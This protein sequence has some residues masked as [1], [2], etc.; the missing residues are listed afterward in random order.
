MG[1]PHKRPKPNPSKGQ[2][3]DPSKAATKHQPEARSATVKPTA[4]TTSTVSPPIATDR[5]E[6]ASNSSIKSGVSGVMKAAEGGTPEQKLKQKASWYGTW[7]RKSTASTQIARETILADKPTNGSTSADLNRF[8]PKKPPVPKTERPPSMYLGKSKETSEVTMSSTLEGESPLNTDNKTSNSMTKD[9]KGVEENGSSAPA[10]E[11]TAEPKKLIEGPS[12]Q[13]ELPPGSET[14]ERPATASGWLGGW[15]STPK[16]QPQNLAE[17]G[18]QTPET[19]ELSKQAE[20]QGVVEPQPQPQEPLPATATEEKPASI[21]AGSTSWFGLWSTAAPS[22]ATEEPEPKVLVK[23]TEADVD[24][25]M[26]DAPAPKQN[27]EPVAESSSWAFWST[28]TSKKAGPAG[29][30]LQDVG[31]VA[32]SGEPSQK[33]PE[34]AKA[35]TPKE[36]KIDKSGKRR[37]PQSTETIESLRP[38]T[39]AASASS[40]AVQTPPTVAKKVPPNLLIPSVK[41]TYRLVE[42]PSILQQ[43]ARLLLHAQQPPAKHVFL[44][45]EPPM[46]KKALAIGIH[47]LF[48]APLLR[49]VMGQ[50]TGTSV[51]F[52]N[53]AADAIRRWTDAHGSLDCEIEK[54]ALEGEGKIADRADNL[55]KLLLNWIDHVRKADFILVACH[56]QGVPVALML[57]A[58]LI[59]FGVVTTG[60]IGVC[61]MAGVSLGPFADYKSRLFSGSAGELFEFA[62]PESTVSKRY[63][64]SLRVAVK[65]GVRVTYCGSIDDQLISMES[66]IF[67]TASHPY[68]Y[69]AVFVD[70]RIHAPDFLSHLVGFALKLRNLGVSDHGLI[71]EL[72]APLAGSLYTG[73][74]H[75]RLYDDGNI[76]DVAVEFAL[77]TTSVGDI[78]LELKKYEIP[79]TSNPYVLPWIMRGLLEED[80]VKTEL[81]AETTELL[82]EFDDWK[83]ATKVL[84]DVKYRLE[85]VRSKL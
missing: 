20:L 44:V 82:K 73:E 80:F 75:S 55:W 66:S 70:G 10:D 22:T 47:G 25:V 14:A 11:P 3:Q 32:V 68:I 69:R 48:P 5:S 54:V 78:P 33:N 67:S 74:G 79:N 34:P 62:D 57:V 64:D 40:A 50:P 83:P 76:Y 49:T 15:L 17:N 31:Q 84:K 42:N 65:Y 8:E 21:T 6:N 37:R 72:S 13:V 27:P 53:K 63:E 59:E 9:D 58:K 41:Q 61:A 71:R 45:K 23:T 43:I 24:T 7:P 29:G 19:P 60:R 12:T 39:Q 35:V 85:A 26:E 51:R 2:G 1:S 81:S 77:E 16:A 56:S 18:A 28:D 46:I 38:S 4:T 36:P 52:A 30:N